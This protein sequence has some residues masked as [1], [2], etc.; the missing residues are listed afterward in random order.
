M[1]ALRWALRDKP[2]VDELDTKNTV[3]IESIGVIFQSLEL[4]INCLV[5]REA[6]IMQ[7]QVRELDENT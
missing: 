4:G 3:M 1:A 2:R 5:A 6:K 7:R